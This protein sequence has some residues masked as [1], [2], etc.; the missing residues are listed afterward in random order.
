MHLAGDPRESI[1]SPVSGRRYEADLTLGTGP[2][3]LRYE[4]YRLS[5]ISS[6]RAHG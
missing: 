4:P 3:H 1:F 2:Y 5:R 6:I